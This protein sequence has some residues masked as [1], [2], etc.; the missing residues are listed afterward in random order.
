MTH[1][2]ND[3]RDITVAADD[4][5]ADMGK[6]FA[7]ASGDRRVIVTRGDETVCV[8]GGRFPVDPLDAAVDAWRGLNEAQRE[9]VYGMIKRGAD[10]HDKDH[11]LYLGEFAIDLLRAA[12]VRS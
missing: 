7:M 10:E 8:I 4:F 5:Y 9:F 12:A 2:S 1:D 11:D 6:W 3:S